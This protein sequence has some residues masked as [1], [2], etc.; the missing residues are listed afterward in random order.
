MTFI[1]HCLGGATAIA[2][3]DT[4]I[5]SF[6]AD[7]TMFIIGTLSATLPD[8]D[9]SRSF[10]GRILYPVAR[11]VESHVG[12]RTAT[13]SFVIA[14]LFSA[15]AGWLLSFFLGDSL[16]LWA[17]V[18]FGGYVSHIVLDWFTR[19]GAQ[20]Y[21]PSTVWCVMPKNRSW[22]IRTGSAGEMIFV[23]M[24]L[25]FFAVTFQ[26]S[27]EEVII[28]F[29]S[30]FIQ[31]KGYELQRFEMQKKEATHGMSRAEIDSLFKTGII[32]PIEKREMM[33]ELEKIGINE[34]VTRRMYGLPKPHKG[35]ENSRGT[36]GGTEKN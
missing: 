20:S 5:P 18:V 6:T 31:A 36:T 1:T 8:V 16:L 33:Y 22:R 34:S 2:L 11:F 14:I 24:L 32:T 19:E 12:H 13:H 27:R 30:S 3:L 25:V 9:Y 4:I 35:E 23:V 29:R 28:W 10:V 26:P 15:L 7:K 17:V 21:W